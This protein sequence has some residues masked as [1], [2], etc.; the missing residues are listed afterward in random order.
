[1]FEWLYSETT[2][3]S[4]FLKWVLTFTSTFIIILFFI[5]ITPRYI[6]TYICNILNRSCSLIAK[7]GKRIAFALFILS[8]LSY[9]SLL[10]L[11]N[12]IDQETKVVN[13]KKLVIIEIDDFWNLKGNHF[14][15]YG[16]STEN[17]ESVIGL[18]E[19]HGFT[20]TL[21]VSPYVFVEETQDILSLRDDQ[22]TID[23]LILKKQN[24]HE[25]AMHG[26]AHCRN[27]LYCPAYE[28]NYLNIL[29]GKRELDTLFSQNTLTY[30]PPGNEWSESQYDNVKKAGFLVIP[31]THVEQPYWDK[32]VLITQRGFDVVST[33]DW[34]NRD[35]M[36]YS[37]PE[38][39]QAYEQSDVF[40]IQLH[41]NTF[42]SK[43][44][45]DDFDK[46]LEFLE[47]EDVKVVTYEKAYNLLKEK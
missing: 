9:V 30:L 5:L 14:R 36:H 32:D 4:S 19:D 29:Q 28:E 10:L 21:G 1:M 7:N 20:A 6:S 39:I 37:Y 13:S 27:K 11:I 22:G 8:I 2:D 31:N 24:G 44:K 46:F 45:L 43:E 26:Y 41:C 34:Y 33:W 23:Y 25:L 42:D 35:Y 47:S 16:Y 40:I 17:Y 18:I 3:L 15:K 12:Q 38:W